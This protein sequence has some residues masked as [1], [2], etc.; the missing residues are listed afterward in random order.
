MK[1]LICL[2]VCTLAAGAAS[3]GE[4]GSPAAPPRSTSTL[5]KTLVDADGDGRL[6]RGPG[7]PL[8]MRR[9]LAVARRAFNAPAAPARSGTTFVQLTDL[10]ARDEES[11]ARVPFLDR[12]GDP[13]TST[14]RPHEAL[15]HQVATAAV[16]AVNRLSPEGVVVTGDI[17]D[18]AQ[19]NELDAALAILDGGRVR[20][21]SGAR[22]YDG[23]QEERNPDPLYYRPETDAP[24]RPGLVRDAQQP[25]DS[26]GLDVPWLPV[27]G[28]HDILVQG[29]VTPT[30]ELAA[31][32][33]GRRAI[34][35]LEAG[36]EIPVA[37]DD[38]AAA[39]SALLD[40]TL[41]SRDRRVPADVRRRH[42]TPDKFARRVRRP[43]RAGRLDYAA[44]IGERIRAIVLDT[45]RRNGGSSGFVSPRQVAWLERELARRGDSWAVVFSHHP[46]ETASGGFAALRALDS[47]PRIA[48][49]VSGHRHRNVIAPRRTADGGYWLI[50]TASLADFPQQARAFRLR[51]RADGGAVLETWMIDHDGAGLA[52]DARALAF[53]DV[54]GGRPRGFAGVPG[55]RNAALE[56]APGG[57]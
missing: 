57:G 25:F 35:S 28:N 20:P 45:T 17:L 30:P 27:L 32:A 8:R 43:L 14:F 3:C 19:E 13:F 54:Q 21:D 5:E 50:G 49:V 4:P 1:A 36:A 16:R 18:S 24:R 23:V 39:V 47:A 46:L 34:E 48:A 15:S 37:E 29:E 10:H 56:L 22:G 9:E 2:L 26:P 6:E 7:E 31:A 51:E 41:P 42:V 55:D 11:P 53:L 12:L 44:D 40:G 33:T 52:G 38:P